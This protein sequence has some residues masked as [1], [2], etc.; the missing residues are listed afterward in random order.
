MRTTCHN[1]PF[2]LLAGLLLLAGPGSATAQETTKP[3][4]KA[5][6]TAK[7]APAEPAKE[8][9]KGFTFRVDP[10]VLGVLHSHVDTNS[11][12][13]QEYRDVSSGFVIPKLHLIG[14][15]TGDRELD[16]NAENV[17]REDARYT[18]TY[19]IPGRYEL[20]LDY[21]KIP[22]HFGNDGHMLWTRT[23][24]GRLEI[25]DPVQAALQ[26]A[27]TTQFAANPAGV[28]FAFLNRT[29]SPS[30]PRPRPTRQGSA[31]RHFSSDS[32]LA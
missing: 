5:E 15:G 21:N 13:W 4:D 9:A 2:L 23:G 19:G 17:R 22:H 12:K 20:L 7:A 10:L 32:A 11:S 24:P 27:I 14:E 30:R 3:Q 29:P 18:L 8:P 16:L 26:G 28:N 6:E 25:A 1:K 31:P